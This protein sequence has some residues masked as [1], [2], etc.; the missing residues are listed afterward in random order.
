MML[1]ILPVLPNQEARNCQVMQ[2]LWNLLVSKYGLPLAIAPDKASFSTKKH[3]D[4]SYVSTKTCCRSSLEVPWRLKEHIWNFDVHRVCNGA[5]AG[6][7]DGSP[8]TSSNVN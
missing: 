6:I 8:L 5:G 1:E 2:P 4:F 7:C 3:Q